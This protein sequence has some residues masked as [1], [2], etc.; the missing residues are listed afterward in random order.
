MPNEGLMP[1][2]PLSGRTPGIQQD[3]GAQLS[4]GHNDS[5]ERLR[6]LGGWGGGAR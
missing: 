6:G 4:D 1:S 2:R 5:E 3:I